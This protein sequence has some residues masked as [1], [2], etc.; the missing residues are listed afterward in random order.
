[1]TPNVIR[2]EWHTGATQAIETYAVDVPSEF[3]ADLFERA[4]K[5][6]GT[7]RVVWYVVGDLE[8]TA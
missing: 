3:Y 2:L 7:T 8:E 4:L 5:A 1:M 6:A